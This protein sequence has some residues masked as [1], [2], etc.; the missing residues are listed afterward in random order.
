MSTPSQDLSR[1]EKLHD[2]SLVYDPTPSVPLGTIE[3]NGYFT[4]DGV[5][6]ITHLVPPKSEL[7]C[8]TIYT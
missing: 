1:L 7:T 6:R 8:G 2:V 3:A 4:S 5:H